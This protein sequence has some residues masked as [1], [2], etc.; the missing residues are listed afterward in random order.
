MD[1]VTKRDTQAVHMLLLQT[2]DDNTVFGH[3]CEAGDHSDEVCR[4]LVTYH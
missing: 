2:G 3:L 1:A 4:M